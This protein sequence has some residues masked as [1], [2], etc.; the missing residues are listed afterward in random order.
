MV[1]ICYRVISPYAGCM[2]CTTQISAYSSRHAYSPVTDAVHLR[3]KL[4][5]GT[6]FCVLIKLAKY[7]RTPS[8]TVHGCQDMNQ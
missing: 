4:V 8:G 6:L 3:R 5:D 2:R 7:S 1:R